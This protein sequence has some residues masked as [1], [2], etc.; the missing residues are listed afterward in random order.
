MKRFDYRFPEYKKTQVS[1]S[2]QIMKINDEAREIMLATDLHEVIMETLDVIH[3]AET[4]LRK[5][6]PEEVQNAYVAVIDKNEERGY[7]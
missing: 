1:V 2:K 7:Y 4:L 5:C 6:D 3:A